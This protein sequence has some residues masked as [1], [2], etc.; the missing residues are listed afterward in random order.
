MKKG[1][2]GSPFCWPLPDR[3]R[4]AIALL[5]LPRRAVL[6]LP[7]RHH[8]TTRI[9]H[10]RSVGRVHRAAIE[11]HHGSAQSK[12]RLHVVLESSTN[13]PQAYLLSRGTYTSHVGEISHWSIS[14]FTAAR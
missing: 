7:C 10:H 8:H 4:S 13:R 9:D 2:R 14:A 5:G 6:A 12:H 11:H 1:S 3:G